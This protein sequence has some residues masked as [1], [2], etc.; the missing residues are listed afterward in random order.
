MPSSADEPVSR[1]TS[2]DCATFCIHVPISE[3]SWPAKN[4]WKLRCR[5]ARRVMR[6][7]DG[8]SGMGSDPV[9]FDFG[10]ESAEFGIAG[11]QFNVALFGQRSGEPICK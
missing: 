11:H 5:S 9:D 6:T 8:E 1:Y 7:L 3:M 2:H 10:F 4:N